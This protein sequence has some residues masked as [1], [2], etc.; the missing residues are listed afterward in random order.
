MNRIHSFGDGQFVIVHAHFAEDQSHT[1]PDTRSD[2][3]QHSFYGQFQ[4]QLMSFLFPFV[5]NGNADT[6][7]RH[8]HTEPCLHA[9]SFA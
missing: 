8:E 4:L 2:A 9:E 7:H 3:E 5:Q 1:L 6:A